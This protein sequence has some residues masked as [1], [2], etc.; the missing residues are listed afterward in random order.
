MGDVGAIAGKL[1]ARGVAGCR[2]AASGLLSHS[3]FD[4]ED[5]CGS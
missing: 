3:A 5:S 4:E 1:F 2:L